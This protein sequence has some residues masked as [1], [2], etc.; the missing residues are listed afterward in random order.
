MVR[1]ALWGLI[2][3]GVVAGLVYARWPKNAEVTATPATQRLRVQAVVLQPARVADRL[4]VT[5]TV[6]AGEAVE[7]HSEISGIVEALFFE[8]GRPV[9]QGALLV[10]LN[11]DELQAQLRQ[12]EARVQLVQEQ[13]QRQEQL[14]E[15]GGVSQETVDATRSEAR[16]LQAQADLIRAQLAKTEVRAPFSG[17]IGLRSISV[18]SYVTPNTPIALLQALDSVKIEFAVPERYAHRV[19]VGQRIR[20]TVE[21]QTRTFEGRIYAVEPRIDESTRMLRVRAISQNSERLLV[22]GAFARIELIFQEIDQALL[23]PAIAVIPEMGQSKVFVYK[24]GQVAV[25]YIT[26]G[27]RLEDSVQV[28]EGLQPQDTVMITGMQLLQPGMPVEV[29]VV[30]P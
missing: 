18:G 12:V 1:K 7:L 15:R 5:G 11:D 4:T 10:R 9:Q 3:L 16:V 2:G 17:V 26:L 19:Q 13:L 27:L 20:F 14:L 24:S 25:R 6:R 28:L 21:G 29:E 22:P 8:E 23:V 30:Q